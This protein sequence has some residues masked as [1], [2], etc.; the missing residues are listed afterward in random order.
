MLTCRHGVR[1]GPDGNLYAVGFGTG[2]VLKYDGSNGTFLEEFVANGVGSLT[3][4]ADL[5]FFRACDCPADVNKTGAVDFADLLEVL[6][7]WGAC[8]G[9]PEDLNGDGEVTFADVLI[10]LGGW[11]PCP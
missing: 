6:A 10:V 8:K 4:P 2:A 5:I 9:C 3:Q 11:G 1:Y 7:A